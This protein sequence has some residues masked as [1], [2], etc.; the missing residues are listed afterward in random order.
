MTMSRCVNPSAATSTAK[1]K[2]L[3]NVVHTLLR[4]VQVEQITLV[5]LDSLAAATGGDASAEAAT[6]ISRALRMLNVGALVLAHVPK[7]IAEGQQ[8]QTIYGSV[9]HK[10]LARSTWEMKKE[11][12]VGADISILALAHR[13]ANLSRKHETLGFKVTQNSESTAMHYEA[14]DLNQSAELAA[15]LPLPARIRNLLDSDGLPRTKK[16]I[17]AELGVKAEV[18]QA[19]LSKHKGIKWH[20]LGDNREAQWIVFNR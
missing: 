18:V 15:V 13:K 8:E 16:Q 20:M 17:A 7:T 5:I 3:W 11:Q 2:L 4:R 1:R 6:K 19:I 12:D 10:N 14:F 9:F